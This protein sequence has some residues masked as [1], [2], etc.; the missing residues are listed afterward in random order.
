[1]DSFKN[2]AI[3]AGGYS[4]ELTEFP[5]FYLLEI[6]EAVGSLNKLAEDIFD[7]T[8]QDFY[9]Q[10]GW[11]NAASILN[12]LSMTG[13]KPLTLK[14]FVAAGNESWF[15]NTKRWQKLI[16]GFADA[17]KF[18]K[19][20][21][22]GGE[23]QTLV[24]IVNPKSVVLAGSALGIIQPR[25]RI[26]SEQKIKV[27]DR[28]ILL[29]SSGVHT[30]GITLIR[31]IFK[32]EPQVL[33]G[34]IRNKTAIYSPLINTL[35]ENEVELHFASHITGHG[36]RKIMRSKKNFTYIIKKIPKTQPIFQK[37]RQKTGMNLS[38]MYGDYNMGAGMALF[39]PA[40]EIIKISAIAKKMNIKVLDAGYIE[41]G[42]RKVVIRPVNVEFQGSQLQIR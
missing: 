9:H 41:K 34:A 16:K 30:N 29:P 17:A 4:P 37:I 31:Q 5:N 28:I 7:Q 39:A 11:G 38:Q 2:A 22:N 24:D 10:V 23:T 33:I 19:A 18:A 15:T 3:K 12:D 35:L 6:L 32:K 8:G 13:A 36:W 40:K 26:L 21:W 1:M 25:S 20:S 27:G 14:L 42:G